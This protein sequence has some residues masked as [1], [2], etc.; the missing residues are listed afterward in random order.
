VTFFLVRVKSCANGATTIEFAILAPVMFVMLLG[1]LQVG[2]AMQSY[3]SLRGIAAD[4]ARIVAVEYQKSNELTNAQIQIL[5]TT[6]AI[7]APYLLDN[8]SVL[9]T[10]SDADP[11][12]VPDAKELALTISYT[13]PS[14]LTFIDLPS[15]TI[16]YKYPIFVAI[17]EP[18]PV[19]SG[20]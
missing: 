18:D 12:R 17:D 19:G 20:S 9:V 8:E 2:M 15:T 3:N 14:V 6:T 10:V 13:V 1:V 4:I 16:R 5:G 7:Q 11:Q